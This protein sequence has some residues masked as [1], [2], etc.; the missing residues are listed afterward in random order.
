MSD[1]KSSDS[2]TPSP[3]SEDGPKE[4]FV[5][6]NIVKA[7]S[8]FGGYGLYAKGPIHVGEIVS[9]E[10]KQI[11]EGPGDTRK[12]KMVMTIEQ[13]RERWPDEKEFD[14]YMAWAYQIGEGVY[15]G[16]IDENDIGI[17]T[18][19]NHSCD[20][21]SWWYD[22]FTLIARREIQA[23]DEVTFDYGTCESIPNPEMPQCFCGSPL[24]RGEV[25][26]EDY[27]RPDL[28]ER[29]GNH[30]VSYLL[31]RQKKH[32]E[33]QNRIAQAQAE[34]VSQSKQ[35]QLKKLS[36]DEQVRAGITHHEFI[37]S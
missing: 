28:Q 8:R 15:L 27:L 21:N 3:S 29:Y 2:L 31:E 12:G 34:G 4:G 30:F 36:A 16:P 18:Y 35:A 11:Y 23:G 13:M 7:P 25:L 1:T 32:K 9:W 19:Q 20:P 33:E 5:H 22:D 17:T 24:C 6:T 37:H 10:H 26:P 14:K